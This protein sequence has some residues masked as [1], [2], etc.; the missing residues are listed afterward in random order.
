MK[1]L[2]FVLLLLQG[3]ELIGQQNFNLAEAVKYALTNH[4]SI[5]LANLENLDALWS[6]REAK[7]I[8]MPR[9]TANINYSY[10][11]QRPVNPIEDFISPAVY[12]VLFQ[13]SLIPI[14][15][16]GDP[17]I[18]EFSFLRKNQLDIGVMGE[19]LVFDGNFLKG[20]KAA[21]M[22][23]DLAAKQVQLSEQEII[24]NV[25]RAYQSVLIAE[26]N[27]AIIQSNIDNISESLRQTRI[28]YENGFAEELDVDRL[29]LS[30]QNLNRENEKLDQLILIGYNVLKYQ[31][32]F[33]L[34]EEL[35]ISESLENVVEK[36]L[37]SPDSFAAEM[38]P[39]ERPEHRL[40]VDAIELDKAD[41]IRIKQGYIPSVSA[42]VG[43]NQVLQRDDLFDGNEAGFLDNGFVGLKA[44]I[45]IYDGG[46]TRSKIERKKITIEKREMELSEFDRA[47]YLQVVNALSG[48]DNAKLNLDNAKRSLTLNEKIY[49]KSQI[50]YREGVGSSIELSQAEASLYQ[51]QAQYIN[52][53]YD[54]LN[55]KTELEIATGE[56]LKN[57]S[58]N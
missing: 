33:P 1:K 50:K 28:I 5:R 57:H 41:L 16:L 49:N 21:R 4:P 19:V 11:Y 47:M 51:S 40:L 3:I 13:E 25:T 6:Y 35:V 14:R 17:R 12:G 43:Y 15:D 55:S 8:G 32:A 18:F 30:L 20:L 7:S 45:P 38:N 31:M 22:Y 46:S 9:I 52:A 10:F 42:S 2:F 53:L 36:L 27:R 56:I 26:R 24:Q 54:L 58:N 48:L 44:R 34:N 23:M 29:E 37:I 39:N